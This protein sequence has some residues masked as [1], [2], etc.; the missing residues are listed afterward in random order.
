M[1]NL[2]EK[3]MIPQE[4]A[5]FSKSVT[6]WW[7]HW[8]ISQGKPPFVFFQSAFLLG[9]FFS[10]ETPLGFWEDL[11][12][13]CLLRWR[14]CSCSLIYVFLVHSEI[15]N[16]WISFFPLI[17]GKTFILNDIFFV[18][19]NWI[20]GLPARTANLKMIVVLLSL[21]IRKLIVRVK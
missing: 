7:Y 4:R 21:N 17:F 11:F 14:T 12:Q 13:F 19:W 3:W 2:N 18:C 8:V 20:K 1:V 6:W 9:N 16:L 15:F 5:P 10:F